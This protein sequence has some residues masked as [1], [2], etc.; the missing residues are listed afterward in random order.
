MIHNIQTKLSG[1]EKV[2]KEQK[3][4]FNGHCNIY[5]DFVDNNL[6]P[7]VCAKEDG[8]IIYS[9]KAMNNLIGCHI[10]NKHASSYYVD[11]NECTKVFQ[12][13][14]SNDKIYGLPV[15]LK[16][17][18][19]QTVRCKLYSSIHRDEEGNWINTRCIFVPYDFLPEING[20]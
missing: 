2:T 13:I 18:D 6:L 15:L 1:L 7:V 4:V 3:H 20:I 16:R 8:T 11:N 10:S 14:S 5:S 12:K 17:C 19:G 9:N